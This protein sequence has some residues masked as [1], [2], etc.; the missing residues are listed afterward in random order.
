MQFAHRGS[1]VL[2]FS[3]EF[4]EIRNVNTGRLVQVIEGRDLRLL[5]AGPAGIGDTILVVMR[6]ERDDK[7]GVSD[8]I[9]E[10]IETAELARTPSTAR[11]VPENLWDEWAM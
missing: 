1:L 3:A 2:L 7:D 5:H 10:L 8:R 11:V 6:G 9:T 4:I